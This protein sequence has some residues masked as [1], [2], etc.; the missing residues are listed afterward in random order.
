VTVCEQCS[1]LIDSSCISS[2]VNDNKTAFVQCTIFVTT[3]AGG[4]NLCPMSTTP[5][6]VDVTPY[7]GLG[8]GCAGPSGFADFSV[9]PTLMQSIPLTSSTD[10][11]SFQCHQLGLDF[12]LL[13]NGGAIDPQ[14]TPTTGVVYFGAN[15]LTTSTTIP[16]H[17][18]A[19]P[20][21]TTYQPTAQCPPDNMVCQVVDG[22]ENGQPFF[23]P[24]WHCAGN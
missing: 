8:W 13:G 17:F 4:A 2:A 7:F 12:H 15:D 23:D 1:G 20:F 3:E 18:L 6:I 10:M 11:I 24:M 9:G 21:V 5:A 14:L 22:D 16:A 19:L